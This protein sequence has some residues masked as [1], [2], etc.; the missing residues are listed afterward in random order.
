VQFL[1]DNLD[2]A[3]LARLVARSAAL[4]SLHTTEGYGL[5]VAEALA[6]GRPV[7]A[8]GYGGNVDFCQG[9]DAHLVG[10]RM[11]TLDRRLGPY[12]SGTMWA[13]PDLDEAAR[14]YRA[15]HQRH[16]NNRDG[17]RPRV[18]EFNR[19]AR[20]LYRGCLDAAVARAAVTPGVRL[21]STRLKVAIF[22][23]SSGGERLAQQ[24]LRRHDVACFLDNDRTKAGGR[25][26]GLPVLSPD[27]IGS[28]EVDRILIGSVYHA[29]IRGQLLALG[30]PPD[31]MS[32]HPRGLL[33]DLAA[34]S[35]P[36]ALPS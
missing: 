1:L 15:I 26:L 32:L 8:T 28:L 17:F 20:R 19:A 30:V 13:S 27:Q 18:S 7:I 11:V 33:A 31:K 3:A 36:E 10:Y 24:L 2:A 22:G 9:S 14:A 25:L 29:E 4:V 5:P 21:S 16:R 23:A 6:L 12:E 35:H 34:E